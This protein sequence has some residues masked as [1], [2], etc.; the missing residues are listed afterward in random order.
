MDRSS[1]LVELSALT[2]ALTPTAGTTDADLG[3]VREALAHSLLTHAFVPSTTTAAIPVIQSRPLTANE[4]DDLQTVIAAAAA[5]TP[6][7]PVPP[8]FPRSLPAIA[9]GNAQLTPASVNGMSAAPIGPFVDEIGALR[10]FDSFPV[11]QH[12]TMVIRTGGAAPFLVLPPVHQKSP[13]ATIFDIAAGSLWVAAEL[14]ARNA[15]PGSYAGIAISGGTIRLSAAPTAEPTLLRVQPKTI[16]T[17]KVAPTSPASP[18]GGGNPGADGGQVVAEMPNELTLTL[19][20]SHAEIASVGNSSLTLYGNAVGLQWQKATP[21]YDAQGAQVLIPLSP[22]PDVLTV[23]TVLSDMFEVRGTAQIENGA[24]A[25][26]VA[27][28][29]ADHLGT[30]S[31]PGLLALTVGAGLHATWQGVSAASATLSTVFVE[32]AAGVL[33]L[34]AA[35]DNI[36]G[37]PGEVELWLNGRPTSTSRSS[38]ELLLPNTALL[39]YISIAEWAG[40]SNVEVVTC[41]AEFDAHIDRPLGADGSRLGPKLP[42]IFAT[43]QTPFANAVVIVGQAPAAGTPLAPISIALR[44]ALL[45]TTRPG[46]L[47]VA[48]TYSATPAELDT[49]ALALSFTLQRIIPTLPD[50]YAANFLPHSPDEPRSMGGGAPSASDLFAVVEWSPTTDPQLTFTDPHP[51]QGALRVAELPASPAPQPVGTVGVQDLELR[52]SLVTMLDQQIGGPEPLL[53]V[54]DVSGNVDQFG[55]GMA[56]RTSSITGEQSTPF[57]VQPGAAWSISGLDLVAA[58]NALRVFT[59]PA[60]QWEPVVTIDNP[61]VIPRPFPSPA[62]FF[63]DGG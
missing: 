51:P 59:V 2:G 26:P 11:P 41:N 6:T 18:V 46:L 17:L 20:E 24:W 50:P 15:P 42:G 16:V 7:G 54:L 38:V 3:A 45:V 36:T 30:A 21:I 63:D 47:L 49:G 58:A 37:V 33:V 8:V 22:A 10:W 48:G 1:A 44:N 31:T 29:T 5:A 9:L 32:G 19:T 60:V 39:Y 43:Y 25:W 55:V 62:G 12:R 40:T 23:T 56:F 61:F 34:R 28:T 35:I 57:S 4:V 53:F 52:N 13:K 14:L 27:V